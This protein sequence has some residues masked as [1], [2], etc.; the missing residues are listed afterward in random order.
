MKKT[1]IV[2]TLGPASSNKSIIKQMILNGMNVARLN[3]SHGTH[4]SHHELITLVKE[5][6]EELNIPVAIMID[7]KGPEIRVGLFENGGVELN[8]G[9]KFILTTRNVLGNE[10]GVKVTLKN[11]DKIVSPRDI[12]LLNDGLIKLEVEQI[13]GCEVMCKVLV[14]GKLTNNKSINIPGVDLNLKYLSDNDKDDIFFGIKE[15]VDIFSISF[16]GSKDDVLEVRK[17]LKKY[18]YEQAL[19]CSKIES[20]KGVANM[21]EIIDVSDSIMVARGDLGVEVEFEKIPQ[22]QKQLISK[23]IEKGKNVITAT[24]MLESMI[25]NIRPTRAEISDIANAVIDGSSAVMLSGET[26]AGEHPVLSVQTMAKII[27]E[28]ENSIEYDKMLDFD[29]STSIG[30]SIGYAACE[31]ARSLKAK[32]IIVAT[33]SGFSAK[34]VSRFRP[35]SYIIAPTPNEYVY[36]QMALYWGVIPIK[37]LICSSTDMLLENSRIR[38]LQTK[39]VHK[40]DLIV[41]TAAVK[42][43]ESGSDLLTVSYL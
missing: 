13:I 36:N 32:A 7:T 17:Y 5:A 15:G 33:N 39:L 4:E 40:G 12:I 24:E 28:C 27:E 6:R 11:F 25:H 14:G 29:Y 19:I 38:A 8:K 41:Q 34:S 3:M 10:Q 30:S 37:D 18:N 1:K 9:D 23:C 21:D 26:S 35:A 43:G 20:R 2:C 22:I 42:V 31:L 16:V